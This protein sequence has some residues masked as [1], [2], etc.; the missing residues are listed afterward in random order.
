M[1]SLEV[2]DILDDAIR[3]F[4][5]TYPSADIKHFIQ[6]TTEDVKR[7]ILELQMRQEKQKS[8]LNLARFKSALLAFECLVQAAQLTQ[9]QASFIWGPIKIVLKKV[10]NFTSI[11]ARYSR[12]ENYKGG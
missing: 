12:L 11:A 5:D 9:E 6:T 2:T 4:R 8:M 7:D 3:S 1:P 10:R